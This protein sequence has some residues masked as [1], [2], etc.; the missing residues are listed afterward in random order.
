MKIQ[1]SGNSVAIREK[2]AVPAHR[3]GTVFD[4]AAPAQGRPMGEVSGIST[5]SVLTCPGVFCGADGE[6]GEEADRPAPHGKHRHIAGAK[7]R[8]LK[9]IQSRHICVSQAAPQ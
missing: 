6:I 4:A 7:A 8:R 3:A 2:R 5:I 9:V 1:P